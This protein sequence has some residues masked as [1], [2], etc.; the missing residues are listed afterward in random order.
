MITKVKKVYQFFYG[1]IRYDSKVFI[2]FLYHLL[3][4]TKPTPVTELSIPDVIQAIKDGKSFIRLGDGEAMI[5]TGRDVYFQPTSLE[6]AQAFSEI[7]K[8]Y[9]TE[10]R[11]V[12]GVPTNKIP[13]TELELTPADRRVWRLYRTLFPL[14]FPLGEKYA[15][16]TF[17]YVGGRFKELVEPLIKHRHVICVSNA[18]VLDEAF[19]D[20]ATTAF[21]QATFIE[22]PTQNAF[23]MQVQIMAT[24]DKILAENSNVSPII[25]FAAGPASKAWAYH[26]TNQGIQCLDI[27]FGMQLVAHNK[28]RS[29]LI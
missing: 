29:H 6:L 11:Y 7:I 25:L 2:H 15:P 24:I 19:R 27:G 14:R 17:F 16:A 13:L 12:I 1:G 18:K 10:S 22:T 9:K 26:Y 3:V 4:P 5:L 8:N 21:T 20:Y 23:A 28:D